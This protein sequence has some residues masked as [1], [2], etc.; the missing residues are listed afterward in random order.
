MVCTFRFYLRKTRGGG[1]GAAV[2]QITVLNTYLP[3]TSNIYY[4][5][6]YSSN[7]NKPRLPVDS[8]LK[9]NKHTLTEK[10]KKSSNFQAVRKN[11][12]R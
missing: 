1:G 4:I 5:L 11:L 12:A 2:K 3:Q 9:S 10:Q 8:L 7:H 6:A